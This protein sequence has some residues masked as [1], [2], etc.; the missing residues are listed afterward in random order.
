MILKNKV[1]S[2]I[3]M[4]QIGK[5]VS[6]NKKIAHG[7]KDS[8]RRISPHLFS[9]TNLSINCRLK[10]ISLTTTGHISLEEL[11]SL[12][13]CWFSASDHVFSAHTCHA[14]VWR[15]DVLDFCQADSDFCN[16]GHVSLNL[17]STRWS[18]LASPQWISAVK[19]ISRSYLY[20]CYIR[21]TKRFQE[22]FYVI[23]ITS[24]A[25]WC[26]AGNPV[27]KTSSGALI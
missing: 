6:E 27:I 12:H 10:L 22:W 11:T 13:V 23:F 2:E 4:Y 17:I 3:E 7:E 14:G 16:A 15:S 8:Y 26:N 20:L 5:C 25:M 21:N 9:Q 1:G 19:F 24:V 18:Q